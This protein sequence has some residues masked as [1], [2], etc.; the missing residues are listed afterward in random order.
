MVFSRIRDVLWFLASISEI[1][2][3]TLVNLHKK[4]LMIYPTLLIFRRDL[5]SRI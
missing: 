3:S 2:L 5:F 1:Y 4:V